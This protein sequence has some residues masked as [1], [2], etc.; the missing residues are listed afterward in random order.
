MRRSSK[1]AL[2]LAALLLLA[3]CLVYLRTL[4]TTAPVMTLQVAQRLLEQGKAAL[5]RRD[6]EGILALMAPQARVLGQSVERMRTVLNQAMR[7]LGS[8]HLTVTWSQLSARQQGNMAYLSF[9]ME[10]HQ[11]EAL[12][13]ARY[14]RTHVNLELTKVRTTHWL[15]LY[16]TEDWK[17]VKLESSET[18]DMPMP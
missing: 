11:K 4:D 9:D 18:L 10:V 12:F 2:S 17:I 6:T 13:D 15:G 5:E 1:I 8:S 7:E 16:T 3:M 14:Y